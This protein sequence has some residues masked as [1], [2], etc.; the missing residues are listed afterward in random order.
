MRGSG[1]KS[2][3]GGDSLLKLLGLD[4][5][6]RS[7]TSLCESVSTVGQVIQKDR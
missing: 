5:T 7:T 4:S 2:V 1:I 3:S 6:T